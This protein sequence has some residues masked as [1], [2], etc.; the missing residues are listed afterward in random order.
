[1]KSVPGYTK[2]LTL[3]SAY[4]ENAL[5]GDVVVQE[6]VDLYKNFIDEI[7]RV[8]VRGLP[9]WYKNKLLENIK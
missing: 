6:K 4:T 9:E 2:V 1:M 3:G 7:L 5:V 8:S